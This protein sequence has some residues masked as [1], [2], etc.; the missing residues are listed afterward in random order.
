MSW[1]MWV[2]VMA[3]GLIT[4][5]TR[6]SFIVLAERLT[7]PM[8]VQ[9]ALQFTPIAALTAI[10]VPEVI[11]PSGTFDLTQMAP[12]LI[13]GA[14]AAVIAWRTRNI[15]LTIVVGMALLWLLQFALSHWR[16]L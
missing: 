16:P 14:V 3:I 13:A 2:A 8:P 6:A 11:A 10:L 9:R 4:L 5:L 7:L 12:R 1:H 15:T